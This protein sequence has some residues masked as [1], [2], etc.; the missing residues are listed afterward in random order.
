MA[1][2]AENSHYNS[3]Q[4]SARSAFK[5]LT[6]QGAYTASRAVDPCTNFGSDNNN[7]VYNPYNRNAY[8]GPSYTDATNI[9]VLSF[10]YDL[11]VYRH[12]GNQLTKGVLGGWQ[13][14]GAYSIQSGFPLNITLGGSAASVGLPNAT[15]VPNYSGS[16][17]YQKSAARWFTHRRLLGPDGRNLG[18]LQPPG[19]RTGPQQLEPVD[20]QELRGERISRLAVRVA[21]GVLQYVQSHPVQTA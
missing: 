19:A 2:N 7:T 13:L 6:V 21:R 9:G 4:V 3:L 5:D 17:T 11:P 18:Q 15:N 14:S 10:V 12:S 1:E 16:V 20:V 8:T